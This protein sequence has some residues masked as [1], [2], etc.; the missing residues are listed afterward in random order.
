[1][2]DE[3]A[4]HDLY[5]TIEEVL[6]APAADTIIALLPALGGPDVATTDDLLRLD[7]RFDARLD[8]HVAREHGWADA[9]FGSID[10]CV[11]GVDAR[12]A[13]LDARFTQLE[14]H[15]DRSLRHQTRTLLV[16]VLAALA[17]MSS[18]GLGALALAA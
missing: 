10:A 16:P 14:G 11:E 9:R 13:H 1:V 18:L 15:L 6:G 17:T 8:A 3:R 2:L 12:L 7:D 4:R 5:R